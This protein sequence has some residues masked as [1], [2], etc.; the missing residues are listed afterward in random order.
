MVKFEAASAVTIA[1]AALF[2]L[3]IGWIRSARTVADQEAAVVRA[4][5]ANLDLQ[6]EIASLRD[7][8]ALALRVREQAETQLSAFAQADALRGNISS[9]QVH[10]PT[11]G[12]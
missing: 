10:P 6:D 1:T 9:G 12:S 7:K 4:E 2:Y 8:L 5:T 11:A 3:G